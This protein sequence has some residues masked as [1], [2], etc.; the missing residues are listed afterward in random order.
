MPTGSFGTSGSRKIRKSRRTTTESSRKS[1]STCR[2]PEVR[3]DLSCR[4]H[5]WDFYGRDG[6][7]VR[8]SGVH[9]DDA[10]LRRDR[11]FVVEAA[12]AGEGGRALKA[13]ADPFEDGEVQYRE[14]H[15]L[16]C[17]R[18]GRTAGLADRPEHDSVGEG[19]GDAKPGRL[20]PRLGPRVCGLAACLPGFHQRGASLGLNDAET[21]P[22]LLVPAEIAQF[23]K[24]FPHPHDSGPAS[25][26]EE[27][28]VRHAAQGL[29]DFQEHCLLPLDAIG[30]P[31]R[32]DAEQLRRGREF[33][34]DPRGVRNVLVDPKDLRSERKGV[35]GLM[36]GTVAGH[37]DDCAR[38]ISRG[39]RRQRGPCVPGGWYGKGRRSEGARHRDGDRHAARFERASRVESLVLHVPGEQGGTAVA[40]VEQP[41]GMMLRAC[42]AFEERRA[43]AAVISAGPITLCPAMALSSIPHWIETMETANRSFDLREAY[44]RMVAAMSARGRVL[45][46]FSGGVDSGLVARV[47]HDALGDDALAVLADA[48]SLARWELAEAVSE[49]AEIGIRLETV[50]VSELANTQYVANPTNR[51]YFCRQELGAALKPLAAE[52]GFRAIADGVNVSDLGDHRPGIQAMNEAGFWHPL[53]EFGFTKSDVRG[54]ARVLHLSFFDKP[55]NA[56][57]SS[58]I[59]YGEVITVE[60]L[61]RVEAAE[62]AIRA[63]GFRVVRVRA[64]DGVARIEVPRADIPRI[65][66]PE[67]AEKVAVALRDAG[68]LYVTIDLL[69]YRSGS[70]NDGA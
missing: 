3:L 46:A 44:D 66:A 2:E 19:R 16:V 53:V 64:H 68:F 20:R 31:Q 13:R 65:V 42:G 54:L 70:M 60:K 41:D 24:R 27:N 39:I 10:V 47:A 1:R 22:R 57:L 48:E 11:A 50:R 21:R 12:E 4:P 5:F 61:Q 17:D 35:A 52:L 63:L 32:R 15:R 37:E 7:A 51:C 25:R 33:G 38:S 9:E 23:V 14:L 34:H 8:R 45:V 69:G 58:R 40:R 43:H 18:D 30:F 26:R 36:R 67:I 59:A 55:S 62:G 49:A 6:A 56:C 29:P 28:P